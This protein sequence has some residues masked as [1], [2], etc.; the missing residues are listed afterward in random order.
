M[1]DTCFVFY[2]CKRKETK[3]THRML[4]EWEKEAHRKWLAS[5]RRRTGEIPKVLSWEL[6]TPPRALGVGVGSQRRYGGRPGQ[7]Q[8]RVAGSRGPRTRQRSR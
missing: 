3:V 2:F 7:R 1:R 8:C 6:H 5:E 4:W